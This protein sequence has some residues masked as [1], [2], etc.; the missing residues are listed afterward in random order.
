VVVETPT[1]LD[2]DQRQLLA[3]LAAAREETVGAPS[4]GDGIF[5]KL[6]SALS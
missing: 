1:G 2:D 3:T 5:S 6:R 4:Q